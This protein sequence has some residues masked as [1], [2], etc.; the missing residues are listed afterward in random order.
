MVARVLISVLNALAA[1]ALTSEVRSVTLSNPPSPPIA[2]AAKK[3]LAAF[4]KVS[5]RMTSIA[6]GPPR[7]SAFSA[8]FRKLKSCA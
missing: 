2:S 1:R 3:M 5:L 6:G 7:S 4:H 8:L